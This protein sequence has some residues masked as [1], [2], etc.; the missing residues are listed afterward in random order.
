L[1]T[2]IEE[3]LFREY[4]IR[5]RAQVGIYLVGWFDTAKWDV[6][7]SRRD[8]VPKITMEDAKRRLDVQAAALPNGFVVRPVVLE[9]HVPGGTRAA[10]RAKGIGPAGRRRSFVLP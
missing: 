7:D 10:P 2:A 8:R 9:C 1:F 3:Q 5:L 6:E 4:M